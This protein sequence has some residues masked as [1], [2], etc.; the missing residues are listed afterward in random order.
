MTLPFQHG[1]VKT[2]NLR[3]A[4]H[5]LRRPC[6]GAQSCRARSAAAAIALLA[7]AQCWGRDSLPC[8][9]NSCPALAWAGVH[10]P[11][12]CVGGARVGKS[13]LHASAADE[14]EYEYDP[15]P[16]FDTDKLRA[17]SEAPFA[18]VRV[19]FWGFG[20]LS[21]AIGFLL[22]LPRVL[23]SAF[24]APNAAPLEKVLTDLGINGAGLVLFA[25]LLTQE[26]DTEAKREWATKEGALLARL[27]VLLRQAA[28]KEEKEELSMLE[29][30]DLRASR[31]ARPLRPVICI[32]CRLLPQVHQRV[33]AA[34]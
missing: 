29:L 24:G 11:R 23:G 13:A 8:L 5:R 33:R 2:G 9:S 7:F 34:G 26:L 16:R 17:E 3:A 32:G 21:T 25:F 19:L 27:P 12:G 15:A 31:A 14:P 28:S 30:S 18:K 20:A 1:P 22:I 4:G 6:G 10:L